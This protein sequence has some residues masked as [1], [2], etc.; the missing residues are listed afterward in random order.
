MIL[1]LL[2]VTKSRVKEATR[3]GLRPFPQSAAGLPATLGE[4]VPTANGV[5]MGRGASCEMIVVTKGISLCVW[6]LLRL[7]LEVVVQGL[8]LVR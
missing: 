5:T 2:G 6:V 4:P 1:W 7:R 3:P 8:V